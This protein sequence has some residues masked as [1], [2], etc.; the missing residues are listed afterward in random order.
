MLIPLAAATTPV[1]SKDDMKAHLRVQHDQHD[2]LIEDYI[3]SASDYVAQQAELVL[4]PTSLEERFD[5]WPIG[6]V[7]LSAGPVREVESIVYLDADGVEQQVDAADWRWEPTGPSAEVWTL[8]GFSAPTLQTER[9]GAVRILYTAGFNDPDASDGDDR[10]RLPARA[11]QAVRMLVMHW[12]ENRG[13]IIAGDTVANVPIAVDA[14]I[15]SLRV[16]RS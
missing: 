6:C 1:V 3:V 2:A 13:T 11:R 9:R 8:S 12:Y 10:L 16:Y 5:G 7:H 14:L 15:D 4:A